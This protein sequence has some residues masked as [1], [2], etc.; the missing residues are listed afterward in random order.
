MSRTQRRPSPPRH[1]SFPRKHPTV[2]PGSPEALEGRRP[3]PRHEGIFV[4]A[5]SDLQ[6]CT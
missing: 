4:G 3:E 6:A 1:I 5:V 2:F